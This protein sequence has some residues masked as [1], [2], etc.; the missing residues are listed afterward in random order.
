[1][2]NR[3]PN[4]SS[5]SPPAGRRR[6][7]RW[8]AMSGPQA[9]PCAE[10][11]IGRVP[12]PR[13]RRWRGCAIRR[14]ARSSTRRWRCGFRG[15]TARPARTW[16]SCSCTAATRSLPACSM[17]WAAIEGCR[18]AEPGE[19]TRRAFDNGQLDLTEVGGLGRSDRR[20]NAG[21]AAAGLSPAQ[22]SDRRSGRSLAA[23][24]IE[25]LALVE[26]RHRFLR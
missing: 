23:A 5:R 24:V 16:P 1:M 3:S 26:A 14:A 9:R 20:G 15:R 2:P 10:K 6:R 13:K 22:G 18:L 21:A 8:C 17:R 19:F 11:L 4:R 12:P 25:A 7:L